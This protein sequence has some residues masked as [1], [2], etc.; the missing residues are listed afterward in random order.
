MCTLQ[1][2]RCF[3]EVLPK[4][5]LFY[6][7][8]CKR[9]REKKMTLGDNRWFNLKMQSACLHS[10]IF[11]VSFAIR[12]SSSLRDGDEARRP[13]GS[14]RI[15]PTLSSRLCV[16]LFRLHQFDPHNCRQWHFLCH[17]RSHLLDKKLGHRSDSVMLASMKVM[18]N[19][20]FDVVCVPKVKFHCFG[21]SNGLCFFGCWFFH[22]L[23]HL[24]T[25]LC[26]CGRSRQRRKGCRS[27]WS[28]QRGRS[29]WSGGL[30]D[31]LEQLHLQALLGLAF[32]EVS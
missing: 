16:E 25:S 11:H 17:L 21:I 7:S 2:K 10:S 28:M 1:W 15:Q 26:R 3:E 27:C 5:L 12:S 19:V 29:S 6:I 31:W 24:G 32:S 30:P 13:V 9:K 18:Q 23:F 4:S 8:H 20:C 22:F 14:P